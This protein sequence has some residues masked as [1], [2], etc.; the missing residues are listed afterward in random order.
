MSRRTRSRAANAAQGRL[1]ALYNQVPRV[2]CKGLCQ[3]QCTTIG[4]GP[5]ET[6]RCGQAIATPA[7]R[8]PEQWAD[9]CPSLT[10]DGRCAIYQQRPMICRV[11]GAA[12]DLPCD[13][14][15]HVEGGPLQPDVAAWLLRQT[16]KT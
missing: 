6:A 8:L 14:G 15:C 3:D 16:S 13:H 12:A 7:T 1:A 11:Y 4:A 5:T 10:A 9:P 2:H